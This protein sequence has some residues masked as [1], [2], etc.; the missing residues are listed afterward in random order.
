MITK[1]DIQK[2]AGLAK[3][4]LS[5]EDLERYTNELGN[6]LGF[7]EKLNELKLDNVEATSHAVSV[8]NVFRDDKVDQSPVCDQALKEAPAVQ[9]NMFQVPKII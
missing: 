8:T 4:K 1:K 3:L 2:I 7:V 9:G 5:E 6:I